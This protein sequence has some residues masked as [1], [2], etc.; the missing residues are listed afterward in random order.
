MTSSSSCTWPQCRSCSS[1]SWIRS[2]CRPPF[3]SQSL[4]VRS[5]CPKIRCAAETSTP[6]AN[7]VIAS[8]TRFGG[9]FSRYSG[10]P[11]RLLNRFWQHWQRQYG[12]IVRHP[13]MAVPHDRMHRAVA[14]ADILALQIRAGNTVC[15]QH[16]LAPP[17]A[18]VSTPGLHWLCD[19]QRQS[20]R[21]DGLVSSR[22]SGQSSG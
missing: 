7:A 10:V 16:L 9:V 4:S 14:D 5:S 15:I 1:R 6:S 21:A 12:N 11:S 8:V 3:F 17:L 20:G 2:A 13:A 18:L 22:H 19:G